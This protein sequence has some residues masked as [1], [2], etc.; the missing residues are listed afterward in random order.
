MNT[1]KK[2]LGELEKIKSTG[3]DT[4]ISYYHALH[5][6]IQEIGGKDIQI[7]DDAKKQEAGKPDFTILAA[8]GDTIGYIEAKAP[9]ADLKSIEKTKQ[10]R[11]YITTFPNF[12]FTNFHEFRLYYKGTLVIQTSLQDGGLLKELTKSRES[13]FSKLINRFLSKTIPVETEVKIIAERLASITKDTLKPA[14]GDQL[15]S[16]IIIESG[17]LYGAYTDFKENLLHDLTDKQF[18][19]MYAQTITYGLLTAK[20]Y[21]DDGED[22]IFNRKNALFDIPNNF[23]VLHAIFKFIATD[24]L[25]AEI[26]AAIDEIINTLIQ[27]NPGRVLRRYY[28]EDKGKEWFI[29]FYETFLVEYN[30]EERKT[31]GVY[32]TPDAVVSY[33]TRS[34]NSVLKKR[35]D[36]KLGF[37][38]TGVRVLDPAAGTLSFIADACQIGINEMKKAAGDGVIDDFIKNHILKRFYGFELMMTPYVL[39]HLKMKM[40]LD[41]NK[42]PLSS[43]RVNLFL[44][45]TLDPRPGV[46]SNLTEIGKAL[47]EEAACV[48]K[49]RAK[50]PILAVIGN[51]PYSVSSANKALFKEELKLYKHGVRDERNILPLSDDYI[52]FIRFAHKHIDEQGKGVIGFI[53]NNSYLSGL[54]HRGMRKELLKSFDDIYI[55]NL[56]GN[57]MTDGKYDKNIFN[58]KQG[59]AIAILIKTSENKD[60]A[61]V[62]YEDVAGSRKS[63]KDYLNIEYIKTTEWTELKPS[64]PYY[65]FEPKDFSEQ[66]DY[67]KF[68]SISGIFTE[69]SSGITTARDGLTIQDTK[70]KM[71]EVVTDFG[72]MEVEKAREKYNLGKDSKDW[73][74]KNAQED[75]ASPEFEKT[76]PILYRPFDTRF[77]YYTGKSAKF[78]MRPRREI[79]RHMK[80]DNIAL[81]GMRQYLYDVDSYNYVFVSDKITDSRIFVSNRGAGSVIPLYLYNAKGGIS[82]TPNIDPSMIEKLSRAYGT[83]PTPEDIFYYIYGVLHSNTYREKYAELLKIDFPKIPFTEDHNLFLKIGVIG[84]QLADRHLMKPD[85]FDTSSIKYQGRGDHKVEKI[86]YDEEKHR[87]VINKKQYFE[88]VSKEVWEYQIGGYTVMQ[89]WL[90]DRRHDVLT[91]DDVS[92][93]RYIG[94]ALGKT[95]ELQKEIDELYGEI[96]AGEI[97]NLSK[98]YVGI[99]DYSN[100]KVTK[101]KQEVVKQ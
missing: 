78:M 12:I 75:V 34:V 50:K 94:E 25:S 60:D 56:H 76:V 62:H 92:H 7:I 55:L 73:S 37:G 36:K 71:W 98:K 89:K 30:R 26:E 43:E 49:V 29:H 86:G 68:L 66:E 83:E 6:L 51:P 27:T 59:V 14:I 100:Q 101:N 32:Y 53:T 70:E 87:V 52:K 96:E 81:I 82:K 18:V 95:I 28:D 64:E 99:G 90:K 91:M 63:K 8:N 77:T 44:T 69:K 61:K 15:K 24:N 9:G 33:I 40:L 79:M 11:K 5:T 39:G 80:H 85:V 23:G 67:D 84:K 54:I 46:Q 45:N 97:I 57:A 41:E 2:Y 22:G 93:Y 20:M 1:I 16:E 74:V 10:I 17:E 3:I 58:I 47:G 42:Y 48:D 88:P 19:D 65:F 21:H 4:E 13:D 35:F 38:D 31:R 72:G